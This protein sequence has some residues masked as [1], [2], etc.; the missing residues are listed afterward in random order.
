MTV[1][2]GLGLPE[3]ANAGING[4][5]T[6]NT[7]Y[8]IL[9]AFSSVE[10][11]EIR[12]NTPPGS[13]IDGDLYILGGSP[14]GVWSG[15]GGNLALLVNAAWV[16]ISPKSGMQ[17]MV[18]SAATHDFSGIMIAYSEQESL[19]FPVQP[20]SAVGSAH[21]TGR[22]FPNGNKMLARL[23]TGN[24]GTG[25]GQQSIPHNVTPD[26]TTGCWVDG[27]I[28]DSVADKAGSVP[29][30]IPNAQI[31]LHVDDT[32]IQFQPTASLGANYDYALTLHYYEA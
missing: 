6:A 19:W 21:W 8:R 32:S 15:Q 24:V 26:F 16:F 28:Y 1:T 22:Y 10:I 2:P 11:N 30:R 9:E 3:H 27:Y 13:P 20:F 14:T 29:G 18:S 31:A 25:G 5:V 12:G 7:A 23:Y 4:H 17:L